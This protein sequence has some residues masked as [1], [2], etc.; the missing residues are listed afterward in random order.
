M[1]T[2]TGKKHSQQTTMVN[3]FT[4][5]TGIMAA[6]CESCH[7]WFVQCPDCNQNWCGGDCGCGFGTLLDNKQ[8]QLETVLTDAKEKKNEES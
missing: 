3:A 6:W 4:S 7:G 2:P 8:A 5:V 1:K